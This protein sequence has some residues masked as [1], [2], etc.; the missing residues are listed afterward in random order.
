MD[1]L[2]NKLCAYAFTLTKNHAN[3]EDIVQNVFV[4]VWINRKNLNPDFSITNYLY[5]SVYNGF[6]DHYRKLRPVV[7][8]EKKY[9]EAI[10]LVVQNEQENLD[11]LMTLVNLEIN[12]LPSKCKQIFLLNKKDGL[13]HIEISEYLNVSIKT[14]E[15]HITRAFKILGEK[16]GSKIKPILFLM[17]DFRNQLE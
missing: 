9:L 13:T 6:I 4:E 5:K 8:L 2:Y 14:V 12:K 10:D 17:F 15:G 3:A 7:H 1:S 11:E 16:L